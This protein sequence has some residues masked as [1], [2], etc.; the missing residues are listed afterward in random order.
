M[1]AIDRLRPAPMFNES[2][3]VLDDA[4]EDPDEEERPPF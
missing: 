4:P 1:N 3:L 2:K